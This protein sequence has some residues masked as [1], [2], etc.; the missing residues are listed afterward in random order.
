MKNEPVMHTRIVG[1]F[2]SRDHAD[3]VA[4]LLT[5][6][7]IRPE[8]ITLSHVEERREIP[9]QVPENESLFDELKN[10]FHSL[11]DGPDEEKIEEAYDRALRKNHVVVSVEMNNEDEARRIA[12]FMQETYGPPR[13]VSGEKKPARPLVPGDAEQKHLDAA[14]SGISDS[15]VFTNIFDKTE[16]AIDKR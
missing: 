16:E 9:G 12:E 10:F 5:N 6:K 15:L 2:E 13:S 7:G 1:V 11:F 3:N 4:T 8:Q 14:T